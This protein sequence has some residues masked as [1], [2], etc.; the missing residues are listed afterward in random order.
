MGAG[1]V[2]GS[3]AR[4][5]LKRSPHRRPRRYRIPRKAIAGRTAPGWSRRTTALP[6]RCGSAP[7]M[8]RRLLAWHCDDAGAGRR[9]DRIPLEASVGVCKNRLNRA[10]ARSSFGGKAGQTSNPAKG[11]TIH[12]DT[13][14]E[15]G[16][17]RDQVR[18]YGSGL[19]WRGDGYVA[20]SARTASSSELISGS[21][22]LCSSFSTATPLLAWTPPSGGERQSERLLRIGCKPSEQAER[23]L[24]RRARI[25][26]RR[27]SKDSCL[28]AGRGIHLVFAR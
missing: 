4:C 3:A 10:S 21:S 17:W 22:R 25:P 18:E 27:H 5:A 15:I 13:V 7:C 28:S 14:P 6:G 23:P 24:L 2:A 8:R 20:A 12:D 11:A 26:S 16:D 19:L 9:D 1:A